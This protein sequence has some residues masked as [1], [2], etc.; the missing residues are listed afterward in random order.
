[1]NALVLLGSATLGIAGG[2]GLGWLGGRV[3]RRLKY[4]RTAFWTLCVLALVAGAAIDFVGIARGLEA[5]VFLGVGFMAGA[6]TG[7]KYAFWP[8][9]RPWRGPEVDR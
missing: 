3:A 5:L 2:A 9:V 7:L 1:V 6:L 8:A 4:A